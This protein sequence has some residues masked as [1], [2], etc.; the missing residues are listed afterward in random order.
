M[1]DDTDP[2]LG[3]ERIYRDPPLPPPGYVTQPHPY[4]TSGPG[5]APWQPNPHH[6]PAGY[7]HQPYPQQPPPPPPVSIAVASSASAVGYGPYRPGP[8]HGLHLVL[9]LVTCGL[10]APVWIIDAIVRGR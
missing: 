2:D 4:L 5:P 8:N 7:P 6:P 3:T 1:T 9:T 10:W